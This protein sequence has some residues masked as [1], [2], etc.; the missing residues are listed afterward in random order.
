MRKGVRPELAR[1]LEEPAVAGARARRVWQS[2]AEQGAAEVVHALPEP[3][4]RNAGFVGGVLASVAAAGAAVLASVCCL[5]PV[6]FVA[7]GV[8]A[9]LASAFEPLR[10][11]FTV[12][13]GV[14]LAIGFYGVYG[15]RSPA[16]ERSGACAPGD[17]CEVPRTRRRDKLVLWIATVLA[18]VVWAFPYWSRL[19]V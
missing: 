4:A 12:L 17:A 9:G 1:R 2:G 19:L 13:T 3:E 11:V 7:L 16:V 15:G 14:L 5:G 18:V 8:G 6:L 10:P